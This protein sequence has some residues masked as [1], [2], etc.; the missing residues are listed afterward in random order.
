MDAAGPGG[1]ARTPSVFFAFRTEL[2]RDRA[3]K[4]IA[5][6]PGLGV[7]LP[8]GREVASAC[9]SILE[10]DTARKPSST[11]IKEAAAHCM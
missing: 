2:D 1:Q 9:G 8:G 5:Q 3:A 10:V 7:S 11:A 6:Q 4:A